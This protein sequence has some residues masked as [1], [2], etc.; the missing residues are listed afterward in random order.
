MSGARN[1]RLACDGDLVGN[2][3]GS[4]PPLILIHGWALDR[5][6]WLPQLRAF[7]RHF[8]TVSY[9][10]RGF[11]QS[12]G[13]PDL[14][15]ELDDID[16]IVASL[17]LEQV[18]LLGMSQGGRVALRYA[19]TRPRAISA[20]ILQGAPYESTPPPPGDAAHLPLREY[21]AL[22]AG[23][24]MGEL[25]AAL[26]AHPLLDVGTDH[27]T[28]RANVLRMIEHYR[29]A[30]LRVVGAD[31]PGAFI[32]LRESLGSVRVPALI[33]TGD[34]ETDWLQNAA[35]RLVA[36]LP[37]AQR[38]VIRGGGHLINMTAARAYN[39]AVIRW[40]KATMSGVSPET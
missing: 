5:R 38:A 30:D 26:R 1:F 9:D 37:R 32:D 20:L 31:P 34:R 24:R 23:G 10:R 22:V 11:G 4:G 19:L 35:N 25:H 21:A 36:A 2:C 33:I 15:R 8:T 28:T 14:D 12:S 3:G 6:M 39:R 17:G 18:A 29:G 16:T 7:R 27:P 40:L 13:A